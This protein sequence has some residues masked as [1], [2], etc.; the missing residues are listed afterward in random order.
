MK[1]QLLTQLIRAWEAIPPPCSELFWTTV[2]TLPSPGWVSLPTDQAHKSL[3]FRQ[4][5]TEPNNTPLTVL[6]ACD[7]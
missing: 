4:H 6:A 3:E 2:L 1:T 5:R 7:H